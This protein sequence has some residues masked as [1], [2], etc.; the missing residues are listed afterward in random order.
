MQT[1]SRHP[2]TAARQAQTIDAV[3]PGR[4]R[5]GV[6]PG[7]LQAMQE[8]FGAG[9]E[10]PL[11]HLT[12]YVRVLK[13][14]LEEGEIDFRGADRCEGVAARADECCGDGVC[15]EATL[16]RDVRRGGYWRDKLGV[17]ASVCT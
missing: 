13:G 7:H 10:A 2:I 12:E 17:P 1:W 16:V 15:A 14:L 5:L 4:L 3:A 6:G 9:F 11:G 8:T